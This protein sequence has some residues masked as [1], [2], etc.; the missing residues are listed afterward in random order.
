MP[1]NFAIYPAAFGRHVKGPISEGA[2]IE[3][4]RD[5]HWGS[6]CTAIG[7]LSVTCGDSSLKEGASGETGKLC[8]LPG[9]FAV[10][11]RALPLGEL[12]S[13]TGLD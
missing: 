9:N 7:T 10:M 8:G 3:Q 5:A 12:A 6:F 1:G 13:P 4:S 11:P 2:G